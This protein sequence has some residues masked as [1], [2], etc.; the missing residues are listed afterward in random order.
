MALCSYSDVETIVQLDLGTSI[1][2]SLT[3]SIIP[4]ADT[5]IKNYVGYDIEAAD[6]TEVLFGNNE[7]EIQL[8]HLP[9][10]SVASVTE[11]GNALTQGN[12]NEYVFHSNGRLERVLGRWSGAKPKNITITYNAGYSTIPDD[13]KFT[14]ARVSARILM[15]ALN[16]SSQ[17]K[18]GVVESHLSDNTNGA[19]MS[20]VTQ[21]RIGDLSVEMVDPLAYFDGPILRDSDKILLNAYKKQVFV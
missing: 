16:L 13:I 1:Q 4:F 3:N 12:E 18:T 19:G 14:S 2:T 9:V 20:V 15:S 21:E 8:K 7:R 6:Q 10:N 5:T 11:D 17:A